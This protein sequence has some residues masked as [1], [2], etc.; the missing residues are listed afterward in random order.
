MKDYRAQRVG[1]FGTALL[2]WESCALP[3]LLYNCSTWVGMGRKEEEAL[4]EC[5]FFFLRLVLGTG[6]GAPKHALRADLGA[7]N[8]SLRV[9]KQKI[10]LVHHI[11]SLDDTSLAK[12]MY[13]EQVRNKWPGLAKEAED[14]CI[15]LKIEDVNTT[16][17]TKIAYAKEVNKACQ[18]MEDL[19]MKTETCEMEKMRKIRAEDWGLKDY[20]KNGSLWSVQKTWEAR[21]YM[22]HVAGNYSHSRRYEATGWRCQACVSQVR[23]D[24][25]HLGLCQG[26]SDLRQGL[27]LERD[28][29]MVEFFRLVMARRERQGWD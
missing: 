24:Q 26:Y 23:E 29:D 13:I 2:L 4:A 21:A 22:L 7:Q 10:L 20:V 8:T 9:W 28:D 6:P 3:S 19:M 5:Q 17:K 27:D 16:S 1:G 11:R 25:D 14:L 18:H 12:M 15:K